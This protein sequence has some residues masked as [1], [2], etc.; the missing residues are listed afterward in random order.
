MKRLI[1]LFL[2]L[3]L[4]FYCTKKQEKVEKYIENGVEV[5]VNLNYS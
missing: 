2:T 3:I 5:I 1:A 4:F